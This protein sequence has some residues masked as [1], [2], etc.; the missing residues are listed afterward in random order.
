ME[1]QIQ[2][3]GRFELT[4]LDSGEYVLLVFR[5]QELLLTRQISVPPSQT[6]IQLTVP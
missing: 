6:N 2:S 1:G 3:D 4:G 5:K